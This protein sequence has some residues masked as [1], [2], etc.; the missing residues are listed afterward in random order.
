MADDFSAQII[1]QSDEYILPVYKRAPI[2]LVGGA[3]AWL[4]AADGRRY[5]DGLAGIAVNALGYGSQLVTRAIQQA[6]TGLIHT[7][8]LFY[9]AAP[10]AL[11]ERLVKLTPWASKVFL[12]NSGTE[13]IEGA[14]KFAR[15][16]AHNAAPGEK[17]GI[18]GCAH[19]FHGRTMGALS[20]TAREAYRLPFGP[21]VPGAAF[22]PFNAS[23]AEIAEA[24]TAAT[25]AVVIEPI[26]GE[27]GVRPASPEFLRALR[28]RCDEV[29]ALLIFDEIQCGLGRTG[30]AWAHAAAG[31]EPDM[32]CVAKPLG[33]GLP[34]GAVLLNERAAGAIG[35]GDHG[36]TFGGN[37]LICAVA[38]AVVDE[39]TRPDFLAQVREVGAQLGSA[40]RD[41]GER[42][43]AITDVR[44][45]GLMWGVEFKD[46]DAGAIVAAAVEH[47]L[48]LA[49]AGP[50]V[51]RIVPPLIL[52]GEEAAELAARL[53]RAIE[54]AIAS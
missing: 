18:V 34:I 24:V 46:Q 53:D 41:L 14:L 17:T 38:N 8:N 52:S 26:Q 5:L 54:Q 19:S 48:L 28:G 25:A 37:P 3:G 9:T 10:A 2:A 50:D 42:H 43:S 47:G 32:M 12:C 31:I 20:I 7:S 23:A 27:G 33:G 51:V 29:G 15:R 4:E 30:D 1:A 13:A 40:L 49:G 44:G 21:L 11:A 35:Y 22:L 16:H 39:V 36:T 45:R 6:A